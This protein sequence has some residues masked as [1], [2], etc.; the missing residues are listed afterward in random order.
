MTEENKKET[1]I[2]QWWEEVSFDGKQLYS[3]NDNG[4]I[5]M[6]AIASY[7]ERVVGTV[8]HANADI[9]LNSFV[10]KF[11][12]VKAKVDELQTEWDAEDHKL[13]LL[14]KVE[15]LKDY[16]QHAVAIG[17]F[18]SLF[19]SIDEK[20]ALLT[21][22]SDENYAI[23]QSI[24]QL[25]E[26]MADSEDWKETT[27]KFR[28]LTDEWKSSG[29]LDRKRNDELWARIEAAKKKFYD[30][31]KE[32]HEEVEKDMLANLDLKMEVVEKA[33]KL[34]VSSDWKAATQ[35][36]KDLMDQW[37]A[38]GRTMHDKNE[39]LW[40][41]FIGA[42]N[43][44]FDKKKEHYNEIVLEQEENY[45]KK[46]ELVELAEQAQNDTDWKKTSQA[47]SELMEVWR[48]IGRV[49]AEKSDELWD[50]LNV[51]KDTFYNAKREHFQAFKVSLDDNYAQKMALLKRAL[52][53]KNATNWREATEEI[54][55]LMTE[56][57]KVGPVPKEHS[58]NIWEQFIG[59][60]KHFF[61]RKDEDRER[62]K[63]TAERRI[64]DRL[65][66]TKMF[67]TK[68]EQELEEEKE[69][70]VDFKEGL[71]NIQP[72]E[73]KAGELKEH[74]TKLIAQTEKKVGHKQEKLDEVLVQ[75]KE[76]EE[77]I[78][79]KETAEKN[80]EEQQ[81]KEDTPK[82]EVVEQTEDAKEDNK[83]E[84]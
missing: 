72:N 32:H 78:A 22:L 11:P 82:A 8:G 6:Q 14:G 18:Q 1:T 43:I 50:R 10:D 41:R 3:I 47:F 26:G 25:A 19:N 20:D 28:Q 17:D 75:L 83:T 64:Y 68:I 44:F 40:N 9:V 56:W 77:K 69:K 21:K 80:K 31:K 70:L 76:I 52:A 4:E 46:L 2:A 79:E 59:A 5:I 62:R 61:K 27:N 48:S 33:E 60:R 54:N 81:P 53:L 66:Q 38:I 45:K 49:P 55:E 7:P 73:K 67:V 74:L 37:K 30:R 84:E 24:V 35:G 15:R 16:L 65:K 23:K 34:A 29:Y 13:K 63:Q 39:E 12:E 51:A 71:G 42:K 36:F 58:D 57:K